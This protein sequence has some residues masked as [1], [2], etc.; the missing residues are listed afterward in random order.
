MDNKEAKTSYDISRTAS[1]I[2][3]LL[4]ILNEKLRDLTKKNVSQIDS[5]I[6]R[7]YHIS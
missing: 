3:K 5:Y 6:I 2:K 4:D 7:A 1:N